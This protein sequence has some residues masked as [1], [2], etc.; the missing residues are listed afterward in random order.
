MKIQ[1]QIFFYEKKNDALVEITSPK[2]A[3]IYTSEYKL[4]LPDKK[5]LQQKLKEWFEETEE[6]LQK[7]DVIVFAISGYEGKQYEDAAGNKKYLS[8]ESVKL[9]YYNNKANSVFETELG[10]CETHQESG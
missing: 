2:D 9:Y 8:S 7:Y 3:N 4:Y 6:D 1:Q 10:D 5:L